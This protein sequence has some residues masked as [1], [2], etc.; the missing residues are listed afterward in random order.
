MHLGRSAV[1]V[2]T[3]MALELTAR[4]PPLAA[5]AGGRAGLVLAVMAAPAA[6]RRGRAASKGVVGGSYG[7]TQLLVVPKKAWAM[8]QH[9]LAIGAKC[10]G[11]SVCFLP[12]FS[13]RR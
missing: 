8:I 12:A 11:R 6:P 4:E 13:A 3:T 9:G 10:S 7:S 1:V 2:V 5:G